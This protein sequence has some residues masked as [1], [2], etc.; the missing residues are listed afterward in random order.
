MY[1]ALAADLALTGLYYSEGKYYDAGFTLALGIIPFGDI[2]K[3]IPGV[4]KLGKEGFQKLVKKL[5]DAVTSKKYSKLIQEEKDVL[6]ELV[7]KGDWISQ[8][9][10]SVVT[11]ITIYKL[12][13]LLSLEQLLKIMYK[14]VRFSKKNPFKNILLNIGGVWYSYDK[15]ADIYGIK[16]VET[17]NDAKIKEIESQTTDE[18]IKSTLEEINLKLTDEQYDAFMKKCQ[19]DLNKE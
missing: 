9:A 17:K 7:K 3:T 4:K 15:L 19:E 12:S 8:K 6:K 13:K 5:S 2:V 14:Y 1:V 11:K 18:T 16:N 10:A